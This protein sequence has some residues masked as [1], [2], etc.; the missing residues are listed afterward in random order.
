MP[1]TKL[2]WLGAIAFILLMTGSAVVAVIGTWQGQWVQA[3]V[4]LATMIAF[5]FGA[6]LF[7]VSSLN[8]LKLLVLVAWIVAAVVGIMG[9]QHDQTPVFIGGLITFLLMPFVGGLVIMWQE[10]L[11]LAI[12]Q[13]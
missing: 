4:G 12:L 9:W 13:G 8:L 2:A 1:R 5:G 11:E 7:M 3:L 10:K 6:S